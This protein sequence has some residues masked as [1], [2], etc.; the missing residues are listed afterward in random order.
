MAFL[1]PVSLLAVFLTTQTSLSG[2]V[3]LPTVKLF[4]TYGTCRKKWFPFG[5][6]T[7]VTVL[8]LH[9]EQTSRWLNLSSGR[10]VS[11]AAQCFRNLCA[12]KPSAFCKKR[13]ECQHCFFFLDAYH[14]MLMCATLLAIIH[15]LC[16]MDRLCSSLL[17][18]I[19]LPSQVP[20]S[21]QIW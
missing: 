10:S 18:V 17:H 16:N 7:S 13:A 1:L 8:H 6:T 2:C 5:E 3:P 20:Q 4:I 9:Y 19:S 15:H 21:Y 14:I 11:E 12:Y